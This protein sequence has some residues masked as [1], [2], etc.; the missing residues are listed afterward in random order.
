MHHELSLITTIA[1]ALGF[2]LLFGMLA[3]RLGLPALVGYLA[4]GVLIGPAT[5]RWA[6]ARWYIDGGQTACWHQ[7]NGGSRNHTRLRHWTWTLGRRLTECRLANKRS[8]GK[9]CQKQQCI[10]K[11]FCS[12]LDDAHRTPLPNNSAPAFG[13]AP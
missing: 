12:S 7:G 1:A 9:Q 10:K 3:V 11:A 5:R 2:G 13:L 6:S 4:A 8:I